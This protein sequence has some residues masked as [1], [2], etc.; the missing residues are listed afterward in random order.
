MHHRLHPRT[1]ETIDH[2]IKIEIVVL[3]PVIEMIANGRT[4]AVDHE[5]TII[6]DPMTET[7]EELVVD[8]V[9]DQ[10]QQTGI[11]I[12]TGNGIGQENE[13]ELQIRTEIVV[14]MIEVTEIETGIGTEKGMRIDIDHPSQ[15]D[16]T[17]IQN[18][19][20][21]EISQEVLRYFRVRRGT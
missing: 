21:T 5:E 15:L 1:R 20:P 13:I 10:K 9:P 8:L 17:A 2:L 18:G 7:T 6:T 3:V 4:V 14:L 16:V 12:G 11:E 19:L